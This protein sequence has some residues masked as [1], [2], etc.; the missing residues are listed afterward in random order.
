M[1]NCMAKMGYD[2]LNHKLPS[3]LGD[4]INLVTHHWSNN[5]MKGFDIYTELDKFLE[6]RNDIAFTYIGR[7]YDGYVPRNTKLI[8]P[9][10]G[11]N[12]GDELRKYDIYITA[13]RWEACG[14]HHIEGACCG[15]PV[16]Y[17][18]N[19]GGINESSKNYG[20]EYHDI[21]SLLESIYK[22]K[23]SYHEYRDKIP[24]EYLSSKRCS[25][26]YYKI[27]QEMLS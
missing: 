23:E 15:L 6:N 14:M 16:L 9:L 12:L 25:E 19:G 5:W 24:Y 20:I 26:A 21:P 17:H 7:Y 8:P 27:I 10:Y 2:Y 3:Q 4:K 1:G 13:A 18:K 22:I 11:K